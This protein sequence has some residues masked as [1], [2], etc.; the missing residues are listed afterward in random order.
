M[1]RAV[2]VVV[3]AFNPSTREFEASLVY[4]SEF[5]DRLQSYTLHRE[6]LSRKTKKQKQKN[7]PGVKGL[8]SQ[9]LGAGGSQVEG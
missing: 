3:Y 5:Q 8:L 7:R 6:T 2:V 9:H 4:K 1:S